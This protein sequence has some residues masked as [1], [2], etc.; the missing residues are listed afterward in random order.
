VL[1]C[2]VQTLF[3]RPKLPVDAVDLSLQLV[4]LGLE[5]IRLLSQRRPI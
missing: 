2:H 5:R 3:R 1:V 4:D